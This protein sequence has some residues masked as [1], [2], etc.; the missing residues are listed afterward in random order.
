MYEL[1]FF[2]SMCVALRSF[3]LDGRLFLQ[4][5][6]KNLFLLSICAC[7]R[8]KWLPKLYVYMFTCFTC[9]YNGAIPKL[10]LCL[11]NTNTKCDLCL[12]CTYFLSPKLVLCIN[13][14]LTRDW[15]LSARHCYSASS[16][17]KNNFLLNTSSSSVPLAEDATLA[18][19]TPS[20]SCSSWAIWK[21]DPNK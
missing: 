19:P 3:F 16:R 4:K 9:A 11:C 8:K 6:I 17:A 18:S 7:R 2:L 20:L 15:F 13:T 5:I 10:N 14:N 1:E 12:C 21:K